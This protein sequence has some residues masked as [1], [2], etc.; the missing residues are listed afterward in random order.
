MIYF[1]PPND[2]AIKMITAMMIATINIPVHTPALK[3]PSI[4]SQ[5]LN[6]AININ[7]MGKNKIDLFIMFRI[8]ES[9]TALNYVYC[10]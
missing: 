9:R 7:R 1:L 2:L 6:E 4:A 8:I 3:I 10:F 5:L